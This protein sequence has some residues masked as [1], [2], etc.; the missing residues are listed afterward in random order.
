MEVLIRQLLRVDSLYGALDP[1]RSLHL[2]WLLS[3]PFATKLHQI[4]PNHNWHKITLLEPLAF[5][6]G[7]HSIYPC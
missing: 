5:P 6:A 1:F 3:R 7:Q 4:G 2:A